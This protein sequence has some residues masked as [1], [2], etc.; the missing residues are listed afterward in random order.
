MKQ[1]LLVVL[2]LSLGWSAQGQNFIQVGKNNAQQQIAIPVN[3]VLE[4]RLP[5]TPAT[6][7]VWHLKNN[8]C[9]AILKQ[10]GNWEFIS[11]TPDKPIGTPGT[12]IFHFVGLSS[13]S[14]DMELIC[15]RNW[16]D[17][18]LATDYYKVKIVSQGAYTGTYTAPAP[19][20][21]QPAPAEKTGSVNSVNS[22]P[23]SFSWLAQS[24]VTP[25]KNQGSCG[26]CW[27][28]A[29]CGSFE[30][31]IKIFDNVTR[32]LSEQWLVNCDQQ[33]SG[34][35]GGWCPDYM[36]KSTGAVYEATLPYTGQ[37]GTCAS[38]YTYHE[39]PVDYHQV[40]TNPTVAQ[41]KQAIYDYGPV[42]ACVDAGNNFSNYSSGVLTQTDGSSV[43]HAIV[44]V[45]WDDAT[46]SWILRNSWGTGWGEN[47]GYMRIGY[48]VSA[49]GYNATYIDYKGVIP[50][51]ATPVT[52]FA[53]NTTTSCTGAVQF[54]DNTTGAPTSWSWTF[55]DGQTSTQQNPSH[56]YAASG[57]YNVTLVAQNSFG[58][59]TKTKNSYITVSILSAPTTTGGTHAGPGVV[60]LSASGS[61]TGTLDW[62]DQAT[63]GN[64]VNTGATYAPNLTA[65]TTFYVSKETTG[66]LQST[67]LADNTA[68][69]SYYTANTDRRLFFDV[70]SDMILKS[71]VIY[72]NTAGSRDIEVLN[73]AGTS[74]A[75]TTFNA[76]A[77]M[78]TVP[79][80]FTLPAGTGYAIKLG[81]ASAVIDL[82]RNNAG[83]TYPYTVNNLVSITNSDAATTPG[84]YYYYFYDW[85]V[86]TA[87]CASPRTAVTGTIT[88][89]N[90]I[91]GVD[92]NTSVGIYPNPSTGVFY[93][94]GLDKENGIEVFDVSGK[95][96]L[97]TSTK[98]S[99]ATIDL[100]GK[101]KGVYFCKIT[102]TSTKAVKLIKVIVY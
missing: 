80:N 100:A 51:S 101:D 75:T 102:N 36:F 74:I 93:I 13:G 38:S 10:V 15:K 86:Q 71:V 35:S 77:G 3:Q 73:S 14:A 78:N 64:L 16:E 4:L 29:A 17:D 98:T 59:N 8:N 43:N 57:T 91:A 44:L 9:N 63:G 60:N 70:L 20:P 97:Q 50:H 87:G 37:D 95:L 49:V 56:T 81:A 23:A 46:N 7:Y 25:C 55:G 18:A 85:K 83:V 6:G 89:T 42:W 12:Q 58:S 69:G 22:L 88:S 27:S 2:C 31:V 48:G 92:V 19:D 68:G 82:F 30:S 99:S 67:G 26:S 34:C 84:S 66:A 76:V 61:G 52:D 1:L 53:A 65:T 45:G 96:V 5:A 33:A 54:T 41:I 32:D 62:Y 47:S 79:L 21:V 94:N 24:K 40:A 28:F 72:A 11:D 39:K 90:G